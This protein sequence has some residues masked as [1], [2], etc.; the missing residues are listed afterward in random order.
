MSTWE[1]GSGQHRSTTLKRCPS[2]GSAVF[3]LTSHV[4]YVALDQAIVPIIERVGVLQFQNAFQ[5]LQLGRC[6]AAVSTVCYRKF[7]LVQPV[8]EVYVEVFSPVLGLKVRAPSI[9]RRAKKHDVLPQL[10]LSC[11]PGL[12]IPLAVEVEQ[13]IIKTWL[14]AHNVAT[15]L[16]PAQESACQSDCRHLSG[17]QSNK[18]LGTRVN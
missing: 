15:F 3:S 14:R 1:L 17:Q 6:A 9:K 5:L 7:N 12:T 16:I 10:A 13:Y 8:R 4:L 18:I 2:V 11:K